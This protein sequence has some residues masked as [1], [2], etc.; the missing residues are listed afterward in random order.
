[1]TRR[2]SF[3][4]TTIGFE[5]LDRLPVP[6]MRVGVSARRQVL[7]LVRSVDGSLVGLRPVVC[8][9]VLAFQEAYSQ[10]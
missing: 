6:A 5:G 1:M 2:Q 8:A 4:L 7:G 9:H 3:L 10:D